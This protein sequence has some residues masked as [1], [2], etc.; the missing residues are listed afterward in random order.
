M[1]DVSTSEYFHIQALYDYTGLLSNFPFMT[2]KLKTLE[3]MVAQLTSPV[4]KS[5]QADLKYLNQFRLP[6]P[7]D[8]N[9]A[10]FTERHC[11]R[12]NLRRF[13]RVRKFRTT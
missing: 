4:Q 11:F 2:S 1:Q 13:V 3:R 6:D 5:M 7:I 10:H 9:S 8:H 12:F